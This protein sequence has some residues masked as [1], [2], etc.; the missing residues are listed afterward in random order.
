MARPRAFHSRHH[1]VAQANVTERSAHH[2]FVIPTP[3]SEAIELGWRHG[4]FH[5]VLSR[6]RID[7]DATR[8]GNMIGGDRV[9]Q[10]CKDSRA[11]DV[12]GRF[13]HAGGIDE[14]GWLSNVRR[15]AVPVE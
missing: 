12:R 1:T 13:A 15:I 6:R 8:R 10:Y 14:V 7:W 3:G 4:M 11:P 5:E 9:A 2:D